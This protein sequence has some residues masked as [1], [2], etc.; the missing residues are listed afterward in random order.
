[1]KRI[2]AFLL[3]L[4]LFCGCVPALADGAAIKADWMP[5]EVKEF[6][7]A[8]SFNGWTIGE[9]ASILVENTAGGTY[10]FA[11]AQKEGHNVLYGFEQKNGHFDY[12]LKTDN[13]IVQGEGFFVLRYN[14]GDFQLFN[15]QIKNIGEGFSLMFTRAD[16]EEQHDH[17]LYFSV[18]KSGQFHLKLA[19]V[20]HGWEEVLV[21]SDSLA[22]SHEGTYEG[23]AYGT[24]ETNLR[25]FSYA[26][27]PKTLKE[28][29]K[30]LTAPPAIPMGELTAQKIK[31]TG[32]QKFPVYSGPGAEYERAAGGKASVS[33]NDWIQVFGSEKGYIL[34][35]YAISSSQMRFGWIDQSALPKNANVGP[36]SFAYEDA[37]ITANTFLTDDPLNSQTRVRMVNAGQ[38]GVKWLASMGNWVY[39]EIIGQGQAVRGFVPASAVSRATHE[40]AFSA[41]YLGKDYT[42]KAEMTLLYGVTANI[43]VT[44]DGPTAWS[45]LN[46]DK[47]TGY[48]VYA[49]H[50][51]VSSL[52][53]AA[54][55]PAASGWRTVFTLAASLP[56]NTAV[57]GLCPIHAATG[58]K[59]D[60]MM[61]IT[62]NATARQNTQPLAASDS[63][64]HYAGYNTAVVNNPDAKERLHLRKN[65]YGSADSLGKY[66]NGT[67]AVVLP[68]NK[69]GAEW[70]HVRIGNT[71]GY[72][73][74]KY[75]AFQ[76]AANQIVSAQP[77]VT[78]DNP[79]G[80]GLNLRAGQSTDSAVI[81]LLPNGVQVTVM[82]LSEDWLHVQAGE[83]TG[84]IRITGTS[85]RVPYT[86][87]TPGGDGSLARITVNCFAYAEP[88]A[89]ARA[90]CNL[91]IGEAFPL[92][93]TQN[94]YAQ[95]EV[96][97]AA[98]WIRTSCIER[99]KEQ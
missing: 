79:S 28:A 96:D 16:Y 52:P 67:V 18:N 80:T 48:Q 8:S 42:A 76:E 41:S 2:V 43:T 95:I 10:F 84:Y 88:N 30:K 71:E 94:G 86:Y 1:M 33:T 87:G 54:L 50:V 31:F 19:C 29:R 83:D 46:A 70:A 20:D 5:Y 15:G 4:V 98:V 53:S 72:M 38:S 51:P 66:Y 62:L 27:F 21:T 57:I 12:W 6:F 26:A 24:V 99:I 36:L 89:N 17:L 9:S 64:W 93:R 25:Y 56:T 74:A 85:P 75:L 35:Q 55:D 58:Q 65:A 22:Y 11:V 44:V 60:E 91:F 63:H 61:V 47:I 97:G 3:C 69:D 81:R 40:Q 32:G 49:N 45:S 68:D 37:V 92:A 90:V 14:S 73:E 7:S 13:A 82:G 77:V 59:A 78:I 39:V 23:T 34:I